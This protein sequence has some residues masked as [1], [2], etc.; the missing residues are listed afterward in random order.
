MAIHDTEPSHS[1]RDVAGAGHVFA[2][3]V[4]ADPGLVW[5]ALTDPG[6][7]GA[8]LYG[9]A[10]HS[11]W[12]PDARIEFRLDDRVE[13]IGTVIHARCHERLSY[14]LQ[15]GPDDPAVYLT[16]LLRPAPGGCA[17]R[18]EIDEVDAADSQKDAEDV[19]LPALAA[20]QLLVNPA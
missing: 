12:M 1:P 10:A 13:L 20:L 9:L 8:Y 5:T 16:W 6:Q 19:W 15:S 14:L 2:A 4:R 11:T 3:H 17:V 7:S 18:L